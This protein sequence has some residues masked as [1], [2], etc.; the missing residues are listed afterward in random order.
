MPRKSSSGWPGIERRVHVAPSST[1]RRITSCDPEAQIAMWPVAAIF[2]ALMPR[3]LV[4][5]PEVSVTQDCRSEE[6][7]S[8][9]QSSDHLVCRL[10]LEKKKKKKSYNRTSTSFRRTKFTS[11]VL[12][13]L[14]G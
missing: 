2:A 3:K 14:A 13:C 9:L 10:L 11:V 5:I 12:D 1:E 4:S 8:E 6:H 7:T